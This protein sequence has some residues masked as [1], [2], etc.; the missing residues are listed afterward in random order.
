VKQQQRELRGESDDADGE[1]IDW[2]GLDA[3]LGDFNSKAAATDNGNAPS[4]GLPPRPHS[5]PATARPAG[6]DGKS[7]SNSSNRRV[8]NN[9]QPE[10]VVFVDGRPERRFLFPPPQTQKQTPQGPRPA[11]KVRP[12]G[13]AQQQR[14]AAEAAARLDGRLR[15]LEGER[16]VL[17]A[18]VTRNFEADWVRHAE[19]MRLLTVPGPLTGL[20]VPMGLEAD[21][22]GDAANDPTGGN[23]SGGSP[24]ATVGR[25]S[26][27]KRSAAVA[28]N[29]P[30]GPET[31]DDMA[32][33]ADAAAAFA[34]P[35]ASFVVDEYSP[36]AAGAA[37]RWDARPVAARSVSPRAATVAVMVQRVVLSDLTKRLRLMPFR[38]FVALRFGDAWA[39]CT[40][41]QWS[42]GGATQPLVFTPRA[43]DA[44]AFSFK[45]PLDKVRAGL[46][47][48]AVM[49]QVTDDA[50]ACL[51]MGSGAERIEPTGGHAG[52][53]T[54]DVEVDLED[55]RGEFAGIA[56]V[57]LLLRAA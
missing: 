33:F 46:L 8:N 6:Q 27:R 28:S 47:R 31:F 23:D 12:F 22:G 10:G 2:A 32:A 19:K 30:A 52:G 26:A 38:A 45:L 15:R 51:V 9:P 7:S 29:V 16:Q 4:A 41:A 42:K 11:G 17:R 44:A 3:L 54:D 40:E 43:G 35:S 53:V 37:P 1:D 49:D 36:A 13:R 5:A 50:R 55:D 48:V 34:F 14:A 56:T 18:A 39:A 25:G 24:L 21:G 57:T 20:L